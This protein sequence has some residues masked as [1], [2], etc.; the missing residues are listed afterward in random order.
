MEWFGYTEEW[1]FQ[2]LVWMDPCSTIIPHSPRAVFDQQQLASSGR[3]PL[4]G[5]IY[6]YVACTL[7]LNYVSTTLR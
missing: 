4:L 1:Y 5:N 2:E 6:M 7:I 3:G